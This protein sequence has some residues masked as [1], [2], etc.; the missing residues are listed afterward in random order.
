MT[1]HECT[2]NSPWYEYV[3][4]GEKIYEGR[5][6]TDKTKNIKLGDILKISHHIDKN[7]ETFT[8]TVEHVF[9]FK[10]FEEGLIYFNS[11]NQLKRVLP[12]I[13]TVHEGVEIYKK[14]VSYPTQ[15]KDGVVFIM[16]Y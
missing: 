5:R 2:L 16:L 3:K 8:K 15:L 7:L 11:T 12:N 4:S 14:Y 6:Q 1:V 9:V 10:T 13:E